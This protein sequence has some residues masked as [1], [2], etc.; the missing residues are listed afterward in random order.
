MKTRMSVGVSRR[1]SGGTVRKVFAFGVALAA[2]AVGGAAEV[3]RAG[4]TPP[5]EDGLSW[6]TIGAAGNRPT[7]QQ[8]TPLLYAPG[9]NIGAVSYEFRLTTTE[10]TN[11]QWFE[12]MLAY[13]PYYTGST[14]NP[15]FSGPDI[16]IMGGYAIVGNPEAPAAM[17]WEYAARFCNWMHNGKASHREAF[18]S[19][20]YDTSTFT[21][22]P[23]GTHNHIITPAAGAKYWM[24]T[25]NE[26]TKGL[27]YDPH[28]NGPGV[29][30]YWQYPTT[31]DVAPIP[32]PP[33]AGGQTNAGRSGPSTVGSYP[34]VMSPWGLLDGS[35]GVSEWTSSQAFGAVG[36]IWPMKRG[37][38]RNT[39]SYSSFRD[40]LDW[41][42][43]GSPANGVGGLRLA[44]SVPSPG[45]AVPLGV[46]S[47]ILLQRRRTWCLNSG[48]GS[49]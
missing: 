26:L 8:E 5:V 15:N 13:R 33:E 4:G 40:H 43:G 46:F 29:E 49:G 27:Y 3:A 22:N 24:P 19:G 23:D 14:V 16:N 38:V 30:G 12:F 6:K 34:S 45:G 25:F 47:L 31:S 11:R 28:K 41:P 1:S 48:S 18:E 39:T 37:S 21:R 42:D 17:G 35:G 36:Y 2:I 32:G 7:N 20:V 10:I 44:S 9:R